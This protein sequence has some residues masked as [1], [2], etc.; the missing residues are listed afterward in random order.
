M[1]TTTT[2]GAYPKPRYV[3]VSDWFTMVARGDGPIDYT[4]AYAT[5]L[6]AAGAAAEELFRRATAEVIGDQ[7]SAG[8][9][10]V[11]DG[12]VRRENYIHYQC[13]HFT[14]FD[15]EQLGR[16]RIRGTIDTLLP[17]IRGRVSFAE[18]PLVHDYRVAQ[19]LSSKPVKVTLPGPL[20]I[21]DTTVDRSYHDDRALALDLALALNAQI[22]ALVAAGCRHIQVDEP[23]MARKPDEALAYGIDRVADCFR[24]VPSDVMRTVHICCGYPQHLDQTDYEKADPGA[25]LRLATALDEAPIDQISIEDAHR[26]NDLATLL[27]LFTKTTVILGV[28]AIAR[29]RVEPIGDIAD[30]L[31]L[32]RE[33]VPSERLVAAPDCGLGYLGRDLARRKLHALSSAVALV[34]ATI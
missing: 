23:V 24:G 13:R 30:R 34:N 20:T 21:I 1:I 8:I 5:E 29:S 27:P 7:I 33:H 28:V 19:A 4:T 26:P 22:V 17:T 10:I 32:A 2:I 18:S 3:P 15:F 31:R 12:E 9:D 6:N 11:T 16:H 25:Y 14:G